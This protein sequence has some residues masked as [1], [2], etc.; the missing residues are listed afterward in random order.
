MLECLCR[1]LGEVVDRTALGVGDRIVV[2]FVPLLG[3]SIRSY[4]SWGR[5]PDPYSTTVSGLAVCRVSKQSYH[6]WDKRL[7][8]YSNNRFWVELFAGLPLFPQPDYGL[9]LSVGKGCQSYH[10]F[11]GRVTNAS[12]GLL[13]QEVIWPLS[14]SQTISIWLSDKIAH[15]AQPFPG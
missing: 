13:T 4:H 1:S 8:P 5:R 2:L 15:V 12:L 9:V 10:L 3:Q 14:I 7:R 6:C 11:Y